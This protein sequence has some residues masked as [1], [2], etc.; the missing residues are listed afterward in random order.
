MDKVFPRKFARFLFHPCRPLGDDGACITACKKHIEL[1]KRAAEEGMVLLKN[2]DNALPLKSSETVALLGY[3]S[4]D[5]IKGG[6]GSGDV[7]TPY[8]RNVYEGMKIKEK[9]GKIKVFDPVSE[10]Y[11]AFV[12]T[13]KEIPFED[14]SDTFEMMWTLP[15]TIDSKA[16]E[17]KYIFKRNDEPQLPKELLNSAAAKCD[18]AVIT[19]GRYS[20]EGSDRS[21]NKGDFYLT[22]NEQ[23]LIDEACSTFK[24][25]VVVLNIGGMIDT[26]WF[27]NNAS[28]KASLLA[29][30]AGMEG[31]LAIADI[32]CGDVNPSGKLVDTFAKSFDDYPSSAGFNESKD[33][34]DYT[35]DIYVGYRY[36]ET[37]P[38]AD[39]KVNY[40]FGF[41]LSYTT[42]EISDAA[43]VENNGIISVSATVKNT[44]DTA[45]KEVVQ[46][47]YNAPDGKLGKPKKQ[48]AAFCK[49]SLLKPNESVKVKMEFKVSDMAS[50]DDLG[51]LCKSAFLLEKGEYRIFVGNSV[52][53][54]FE[55]D[56][57]YI[58]SDEYVVTEQLES[59]CAPTCLKERMLSNGSMEKLPSSK[60]KNFYPENQPITAT[61]PEKLVGI[62]SIGKTIT[63]DEFVAQFTLEELEKFV[64][65]QGNSGVSNTGCFGGLPPMLGV[66]RFPTA[67]GPAGLRLNEE[68]GI[69]TTAWPCATLLASTWNTD[70]LYEVGS[71]GALEVKENNLAIWLT[72]ALNIHRSPLC[73]RNFEY[74][75]EDPLISGKMAAAMVNG[76][77]SHHIG[78]SAKHF[79]CNNKETNREK[80]DSR[81]SERAL[82]EIY[83]KGFE[84]CVKESDPYTIMTSYNLLNGIHTSESYELLG[85]ILRKE[86]GF[87]GMVTTDWGIKND[88]VAEVKAGNDMKMHIGYP[89]EL[90]AAIKDGS[91]TRADLEACVK[92]IV[93]V[94]LRFD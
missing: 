11:S 33:Y 75:S 77:Q 13:K 67:D 14:K 91:L 37:I 66:P 15:Q 42:F 89:D 38:G 71:A 73:G 12:K 76:I 62:E 46:V 51:K 84:I 17:K 16:D 25:V 21:S 72:P 9:E 22:D 8:I 65:G 78:A 40:P 36:F 56:Y 29:L 54:C 60:I 58:V 81:V 23:I 74:Y 1:S 83:L 18:T 10:F 6:W 24:K 90:D 64:S 92:R 20:G 82:R 19:I 86:W 69:P 61:P 35:E 93:S 53:D 48:L 31:G 27:K 79:C 87:K 80:S 47:Y 88:P 55:I 44:G 34:V 30:Q 4:I 32:L 5:Y 41:G 57:K 2:E 49:T 63:L 7:Y 52:R 45:G 43:A 70:I 68:C 39:K 3:K 94:F 85:G 26:E 28:V 50:F 59:F